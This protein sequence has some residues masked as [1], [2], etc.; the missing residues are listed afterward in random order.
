MDL[1]KYKFLI[2]DDHSL[3]RHMMSKALKEVSV[4]QIDWATDGQDAINKIIAANENNVPYDII[5]LDWGMPKLTGIDVLK[6][7]RKDKRFDN[8]AIVMVT[9][10]AEESNI[11]HAIEEGATSYITKPVAS[12][13][14]I[15]KL[16]ELANWLENRHVKTALA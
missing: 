2:A 8:T 11:L 12:E 6:L 5:C 7:C 10:E 13:V 16:G 14:L 1:A 3:L 15:K 4:T 9:A